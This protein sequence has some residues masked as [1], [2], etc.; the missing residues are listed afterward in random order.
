MTIASRAPELVK[1]PVLL[2]LSVVLPACET[3]SYYAQATHGQL[4]MLMGR[5]HIAKL[6]ADASLPDE[7]RRKLA[8]V[9][10]VRRFAETEL[11]L[12]VAD[13]YSTFVD[14]G[15][16]YAVWNVFAAPEFSTEAVTWC[17]L[18]AGCV[19]YRGYFSE[20]AASRY[21]RRLA[22]EGHDVYI[23]GVD[24]YSTLGW[25]DDS[26]LSTVL[27]RQDHQ[28]A[29]LVFHELAHQLVYVRGD[30]TFNESFATTVEREGL[31][32]WLRNLGQ[33]ELMASADLALNR[34]QQFVALVS[35]WRDQFAA[36]YR[37]QLDVQQMRAGKQHLQQQMRADYASLKQ[38]W[39]GYTGYDNWF[40][41]PLNNAQLATV[42]TYNDLVPHFNALLASTNGNLPEFYQA[43]SE[44]AE[45]PKPQR[46]F[47]LKKI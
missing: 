43:V 16:E 34:Q 24:A 37:Q 13:N 15:R 23:G 44:L 40:A 26:V 22:T 27:N 45:L 21:A 17:Y 7:W 32:R 12:P 31:R 33:E 3:I 39:G 19:S 29:A 38:Q 11:L 1:F 41:G 4:S 5:Q 10:A 46:E 28:L 35:R 47:R 8:L 20:Q 2:L 42:A 9:L 6:S 18:I 14:T 30:T 25:F 36:L